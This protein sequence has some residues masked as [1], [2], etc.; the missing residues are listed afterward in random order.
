MNEISY[1]YVALLDVLA[2]REYLA[3]DTNSGRLEFREPEL[4]VREGERGERGSAVNF[5]A[6]HGGDIGG[7]GGEKGEAGVLLNLLR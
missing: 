7:Q 1:S 4:V 5:R 6:E 3:R 2:Y